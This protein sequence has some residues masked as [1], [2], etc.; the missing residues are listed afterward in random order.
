MQMFTMA[1]LIFEHVHM[2]IYISLVHH[3][4]LQNNRTVFHMVPI[5]LFKQN[6]PGKEICTGILLKLILDG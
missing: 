6:C 1:P 5:H 4:M 3:K 2:Y